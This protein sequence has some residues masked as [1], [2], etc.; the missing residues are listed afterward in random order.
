MKK[1]IKRAMAVALVLS[2]A[3][4]GSPLVKVDAAKKVKAPTMKKTLALP[5][6]M[7]A[8]LKVK[9]GTY[10]I[11]KIKWSSSNTKVATVSQ[12]G[13]VDALTKGKSTITAVVTTKKTKKKTKKYTLKCKLTVSVEQEHP[14]VGGWSAV[15]DPTIT[16]EYVG[17]IN[18]V[19][20]NKND[21]VIYEPVALLATQVVAGTNYRFLCRK[22]VTFPQ[23]KLTYSIVDIFRSLDGQTEL[24]SSDGFDGVYDTT[25]E[26]CA[27][28]SIPGGWVPSSS[29]LPSE[30]YLTEIEKALGTLK[31]TTF[32]T[33]LVIEQQAISNTS[34]K[35]KVI[36]ESDIKGADSGDSPAY[37]IVY[38]AFTLDA[39]GK[40]TE[41]NA[42]DHKI[43]SDNAATK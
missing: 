9:K 15:Q 20:N 4:A 33:P 39:N 12:E 16:D 35:I 24:C 26:A 22:T 19:L 40:I 17:Y 21:G 32:G 30:T 7:D 38:I 3:M 1:Q 27:K 13:W 25:I 11:K 14:T 5:E 34:Y 23:K 6:G 29:L 28:D 42:E 10:K 37:S 41:S 31:G 43:F 18:S 8:Q 36:C 2:L